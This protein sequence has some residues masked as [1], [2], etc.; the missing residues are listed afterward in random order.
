MS[1]QIIDGKALAASI[2]ESLAPRIEKLK[3]NNII[4]AL[5][6]ILVGDD[7]AS[8]VYVNNKANTFKALG[9]RSEVLQFPASMTQ[10]AL[11]AEIHRLNDDPTLHGILVQLPLPTHIDTNTVIDTIDPEKDVDGF[12]ISNAGAL[13]TGNPRFIP[14]TP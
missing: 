1:A 14:C 12:H 9:L 5:T 2:K 4:P 8:A 3:T 11:L 10:E 13:M 6:V 7:P